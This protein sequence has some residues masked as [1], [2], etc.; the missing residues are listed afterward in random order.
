MAKERYGAQGPRVN[1]GTSVDVSP[2]AAGIR[3]LVRVRCDGLPRSQASRLEARNLDLMARKTAAKR[4]PKVKAQLLL[5]D[6]VVTT[7]EQL[8]LEDSANALGAI[9]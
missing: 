5:V 3:A 9:S 2:L 6:V 4:N 1:R 7:Y 8:L